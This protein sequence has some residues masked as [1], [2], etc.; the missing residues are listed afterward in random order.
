MGTFLAGGNRMVLFTVILTV[1]GEIIGH[2]VLAVLLVAFM[3]WLAEESGLIERK[4][5]A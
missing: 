4:V 3:V 5:A 1:I 2:V